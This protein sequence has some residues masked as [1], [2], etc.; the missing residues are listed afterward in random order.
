V[1]A[2]TNFRHAGEIVAPTERSPSRF[3]VGPGLGVL[4]LAARAPGRYP[5]IRFRF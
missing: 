5:I 2:A 3:S 1:F 4:G